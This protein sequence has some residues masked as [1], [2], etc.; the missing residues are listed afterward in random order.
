[1][2]PGP[3]PLESREG[4]RNRARAEPERAHSLPPRVSPG[5]EVSPTCQILGG[6]SLG[7][8]SLPSLPTEGGEALGE[9]EETE[10]ALKQSYRPS[11]RHWEASLKGSCEIFLGTNFG[12][13]LG[14]T[15]P[16]FMV[17]RK[18][19]SGRHSFQDVAQ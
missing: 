8:K 10:L 6:L 14:P 9:Q 1:M 2:A 4:N 16:I 13:G 15:R 5:S 11:L 17:L 3:S 18:F 12:F 19:S 7:V